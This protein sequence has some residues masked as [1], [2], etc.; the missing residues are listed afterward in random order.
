MENNFIGKNI[1]KLRKEKRLSQT[2]LAYLSDVP[3]QSKISDWE[4]GRAIPDL[5][6]AQKLTQIFGVSIDY[7]LSDG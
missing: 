2:E 5:L 7:L 6:E 4:N 3:S 1:Q